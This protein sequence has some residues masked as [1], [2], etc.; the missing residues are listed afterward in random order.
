MASLLQIDDS[1]Q[2]EVILLRGRDVISVEREALELLEGSLDENFINACNAIYGCKRQLVVS[3]MGKSGHIARKIAATFTATG[4]PAVFIHPAEASHG[5]LGILVRGDALLV[6]SNSGNTTELRPLLKFARKNGV[7]V[8]GIAS[9]R[10]SLVTD[11]ADIPIILP[12]VREA[13]VVN[14]APT[15]STTMQLALGDALAMAV[16]DLRGVS[17]KHLREIHPGG[18]IGLRLTPVAELMHGPGKLPL[19]GQHTGMGDVISVMTG[20]RF[21]VAGVIDEAGALVGIITDGDIRR[22]FATLASATAADVMTSDPKTLPA[23]LLASDALSSLNEAKITSA[24]ILD[25]N[26]RPV[27]IISI[28]DLLRYGLS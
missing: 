11:L 13:C 8:I 1:R 24:F 10:Q 3:G 6:L 4:T 19:V 28:H 16:M 17:R 14:V 23:S 5:D 20:G 18:S 21:G 9:R 7:T 2:R 12:A 27:G 25:E 22:H 26:G 15:T